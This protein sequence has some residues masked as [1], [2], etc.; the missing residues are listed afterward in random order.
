VN[1]ILRLSW[2]SLLAVALVFSL[3]GCG[4]SDSK[5]DD[6]AQFVGTWELSQE[7]S[8]YWYVHFFDDA[9]WNISNN[10]DGSGRRVFGVYE[11]NGNT[12]KGPM[13]NPG[14]GMGEII[15]V[16][17]DGTIKLDFIEHWHTP[18]KTLKFTGVKL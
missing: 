4:R 10:A 12:L 6:K 5:K 18:Y 14:T 15:A 1:A 9:N 13:N 7:G 2:V 17:E 8:V 11:V 16:V 3:S